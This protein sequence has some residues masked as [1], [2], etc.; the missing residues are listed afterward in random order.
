MKTN[1]SVILISSLLILVGFIDFGKLNAAENGRS[2][3]H[4]KK[5]TL[6]VKLG[7]LRF[8]VPRASTSVRLEN[9]ETLHSL[10]RETPELLCSQNEISA[11]A[12]DT[13]KIKFQLVD[14]SDSERVKGRFKFAKNLYE[15]ANA[16]S[17]IQNLANKTQFFSYKE[18]DYYFFPKEIA[19]T[20]DGSPVVLECIKNTGPDDLTSFCSTLFTEKNGLLV[21]YRFFRKDHTP[22][23]YLDVHLSKI[24]LLKSMEI[25]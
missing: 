17:E 8:E 3:M 18:T 4:C 14:L 6:I 2:T 12:V 10:D 15:S 13:D 25:K 9:K 7:D 23:E 20:Y 1:L 11:V 19:E 5:K 22:E 24:A 16:K 21:G